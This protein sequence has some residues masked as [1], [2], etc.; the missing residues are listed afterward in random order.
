MAEGRRLASLPSAGLPH[1][2]PHQA[3]SACAISAQ[4]VRSTPTG[5]D[6]AGVWKNFSKAQ[7]MR[8]LH[9]GSRLHC[10]RLHRS[11]THLHG[12]GIDRLR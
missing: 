5:Y 2:Y 12:C 10:S 11:H 3:P 4:M 7:P 1:V 9:S 8:K 6:Q